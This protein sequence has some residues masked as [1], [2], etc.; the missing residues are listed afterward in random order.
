VYLG[1]HYPTDVV[2]GY[3]AAV[4]WLGVVRAVYLVSTAPSTP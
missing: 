2:G 3:A 4:I 1:F